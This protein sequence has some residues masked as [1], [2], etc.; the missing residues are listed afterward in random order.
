YGP[1]DPVV[2]RRLFIEHALVKGEF[3]TAGRF[4]EGNQQL[5]QELEGIEQK[6]RQ[7]GLLKDDEALY[8]FFDQ[9]IPAHV[10]DGPRFEKWRKMIEAQQPDILVL[11]RSDLLVDDAPEI[12][13]GDFPD[14]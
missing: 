4:R 5:M 11:K 13:P 8:E 6:P 12:H 7:P 1:I 10:F 2:S 9:R 3:T 14:A